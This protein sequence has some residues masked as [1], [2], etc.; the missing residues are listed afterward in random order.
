MS[1][2][3][4]IKNGLSINLK[5]APENIVKKAPFPKSVSIN[6]SD[7]HLITPKMVVKAGDKVN[8]G[9]IVFFS[10]KNPEVKFCSPVSG[11][12]LEIIRGAKRRIIEIIISCD[13]KQTAISH[14]TSGFNN[15]SKNQILEILL[16][17][18]CWPFIKQ[19]PYDV[20]ADPNDSPK[21]IFISTLNT[22][23]ISADFEIILNEQ[24]DEFISGIN[25]LKN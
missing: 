10:K 23:P 20:I 16:I 3:I 5:G 17:S 25:A 2:D 11:Q 12:I 1:N 18:G 19:R 24:K 15:F 9:D 8:A 13:K 6:P 21:S 7:F 14:K 22:A 4:R